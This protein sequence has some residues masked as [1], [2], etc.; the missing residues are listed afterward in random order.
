MT[1]HESGEPKM[2]DLLW[3][4]TGQFASAPNMLV[5]GVYETL[6]KQIVEGERQQGERL[7]DTDIAA[8]LGVSRTPVRQALHQLQRAGLVQTSARRG[9]HVTIFTPEDIRELYDLRTILEVAAVH[10]AVPRLEEARLRAALEA[11]GAEGTLLI[12][13]PWLCTRPGIHLLRGDEAEFVEMPDVDPYRLELEDLAAAI[14]GAGEPLLGRDDAVGQARTIEAL[15][16][17]AA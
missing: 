13:D 14:R 7:S 6:W 8:E 5:D 10:A 11:I 16:T 3:Q 2:S 4:A 9:F 1:D 12:Q 17:S 15:Y